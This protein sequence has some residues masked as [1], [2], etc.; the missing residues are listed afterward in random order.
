MDWG[1]GGS[2]G[3]LGQWNAYRRTVNRAAK[4]FLVT[5]APYRDYVAPTSDPGVHFIMGWSESVLRYIPM[6][7]R[8]MKSQ[9]EA[10]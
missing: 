9:V 5:I 6:M 2:G 10:C 3:F 8:G 7:T 4:A 1:A